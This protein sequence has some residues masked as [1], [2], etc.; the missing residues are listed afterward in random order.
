MAISLTGLLLGPTT[1]G[2]LSTR[3]FGEADIRYAMATLPLMYGIVP[4]VI[5]PFTLRRYRAQMAR[6]GTAAR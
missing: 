3:V 5:V 2:I 4:L 1:V 6:L